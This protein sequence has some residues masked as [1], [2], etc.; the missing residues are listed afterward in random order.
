MIKEYES[1]QPIKSSVYKEA[2]INWKKYRVKD[3]VDKNTYYPVGDGDHGS[4]KPEMYQKEGIPYIRV[5]NLTWHGDILTDGIVCISEEVQFAN[6]KSILYPGDILIAK[7][8]ATIGKLGLIPESIKEANTTSSVGKLTV[9]KKWFSPKYILYCFQ[10]R[11]LQDQIWLEASQK[12]AQPGFNIDDLIV[13]EFLAPDLDGQLK[14]VEYLDHQTAIIDQL[15]LQKEKLIELLKEKRQAVINEAVTKGLNPNAKMK[16]SGIEWLRE[17]PEH[18]E[19]SKV[20]WHL[21]FCNSRRIPI[22]AAERY[23]RK[24]EYPYYGASGIIDYVD[25]FLFEGEF[26]LVGEDGANILSRS[27]PLAFIATGKFWV[28]NHAHILKVT[29]GEIQYFSEQLELNDF[30]TI[31]SGSAQPKLTKEALGNLRIIVPNIQE[32]KS[33][34]EFITNSNNLID[35]TI[36]KINS[37]RISPIHHF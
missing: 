29:D 17:V 8:G 35:T 31:A 13:F 22:E 36:V 27:S 6:K 20:K 30:S 21:E 3:T 25:D 4:I 9:D 19:I 32:Q 12:S 24:G 26:I 5:Q 7:T 10:S 14:V 33:I 11:A 23:N 37:Q 1:Y 15:I 28:N 18:W 2:P 34:V 16:D